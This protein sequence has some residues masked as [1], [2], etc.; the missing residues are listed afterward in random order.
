MF[1]EL[2][3]FSKRVELRNKKEASIVTVGVFS[4][5]TESERVVHGLITLL[6]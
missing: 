1:K 4:G 2:K 6:L 5:I 3:V